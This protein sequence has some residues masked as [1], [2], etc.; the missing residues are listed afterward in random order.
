MGQDERGRN[1]NSAA[2]TTTNGTGNTREMG[3]KFDG[4]RNKWTRIEI[5]CE[6]AS[7]WKWNRFLSGWGLESPGNEIGYTIRYK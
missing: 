1:R 7:D 6:M 4:N 5:K 2:N 3:G